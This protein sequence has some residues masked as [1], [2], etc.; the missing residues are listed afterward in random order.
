MSL[1]HSFVHFRILWNV[2]C[3]EILCFCIYISQLMRYPMACS[4]SADF[5]KRHR[6]LGNNI[7]EHYEKTLCTSRILND[8]PYIGHI[9]IRINYV[10]WS[11]LQ[12]LKYIRRRRTSILLPQV[13]LTIW[14][15]VP[16]FIL[17]ISQFFHW[18]YGKS[19]P[20]FN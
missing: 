1:L 3:V 2:A 11:N 15:V 7:I 16:K 18:C 9:N 8:N 17:V 4:C 5:I 20:T 6:C 12:Q 10:N 19:C 14:W 13:A